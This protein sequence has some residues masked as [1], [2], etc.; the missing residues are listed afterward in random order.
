MPRFIA[1]DFNNSSAISLIGLKV[2]TVG[3]VTKSSSA[4][5]DMTLG[6]V[7]CISAGSLIVSINSLFKPSTS[8]ILC[9]AGIAF[10]RRIQESLLL[11]Y[12]LFGIS[13]I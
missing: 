9:L 1:S 10:C 13:K 4:A 8:L 5:E 6:I 7:D 3:M 11:F 2:F 12:E